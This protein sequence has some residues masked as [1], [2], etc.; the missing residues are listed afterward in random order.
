[1][2]T[3]GERFWGASNVLDKNELKRRYESFQKEYAIRNGSN[4]KKLA[5]GYKDKSLHNLELAGILDLISRDEKKKSIL[6]IPSNREYF[7]WIIIISYYAMY[8]AATSALAK[9]GIRS[10]SHGATITA[11]EYWY[12]LKKNLLERKYIEMIENAQF[13]REDIEKID[14]ALRGRVAVQYTVSKM[15]GDKEAKRILK[16]AREFVGKINEIMG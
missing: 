11:L 14:N 4:E 9:V 3:I 15:Y 16:D 8:L 6:V 1:M 13:G 12:C 7:D 5:E 2:A 10:T